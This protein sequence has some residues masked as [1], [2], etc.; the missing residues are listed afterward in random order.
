MPAS[1]PICPPA[2]PTHVSARPATRPLSDAGLSVNGKNRKGFT[3]LH[4]AARHG[5]RGEGAR[6]AALFVRLPQLHAPAACCMSNGEGR[7]EPFHASN[8]AL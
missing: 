1:S 2:R 4:F 5:A 7:R 3:A 8:S 6:T